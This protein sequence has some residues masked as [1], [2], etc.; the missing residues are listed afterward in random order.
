MFYRQHG[1]EELELPV[2][3]SEQGIVVLDFKVILLSLNSIN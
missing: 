2:L 3:C 1:A